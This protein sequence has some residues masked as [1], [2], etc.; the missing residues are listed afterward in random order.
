MQ[1]TKAIVQAIPVMSNTA[2]RG[3][4]RIK[5]WIIVPRHN[6]K[7]LLFQLETIAKRPGSDQR[8]ASPGPKAL[9]AVVRRPV[10]LVLSRETHPPSRQRAG[11]KGANRVTTRTESHP[12]APRPHGEHVPRLHAC[13]H[14]STYVTEDPHL[15]PPQRVS[16]MSRFWLRPCAS[17]GRRHPASKQRISTHTPGACLYVFLSF[18][19]SF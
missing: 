6:I 10:R 8:H 3:R 15:C 16:Q 2:H 12:T 5:I 4:W 9:P 11:T 13:D 18:L 7:F 19:F 17:K 1:S 14:N